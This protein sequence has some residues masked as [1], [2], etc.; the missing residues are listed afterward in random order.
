MREKFEVLK[1]K[2]ERKQF[3]SLYFVIIYH[4]TCRSSPIIG[5][6]YELMISSRASGFIGETLQRTAEEE[7]EERTERG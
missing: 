2:R 3:R 5:S 7:E 6:C 4:D 1:F